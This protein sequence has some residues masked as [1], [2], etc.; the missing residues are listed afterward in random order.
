VCLL[1][2]P[3]DGATGDAA[4]IPV[5][6]RQQR[7]TQGASPEHDDAAHLLTGSRTVGRKMA[8]LVCHVIRDRKPI[9]ATVDEA[10]RFYCCYLA[11]IWR[12]TYCEEFMSRK[13]IHAIS[14]VHTR[15]IFTYDRC[16]NTRDIIYSYT[17]AANETED[18]VK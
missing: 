2:T 10:N 11:E 18:N 7:D 16:V 13:D 14:D 12:R 6:L 5:S 1:S 8:L 9:F 15:L 3:P 4:E 17:T